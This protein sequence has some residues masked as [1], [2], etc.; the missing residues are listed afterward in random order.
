M[1]THPVSVPVGLLAALSAFV[2]QVVLASSPAG[3]PSAAML[4]SSLVQRRLPALWQ[5]FICPAAVKDAHGVA[6]YAL[7]A[8]LPAWTALPVPPRSL[9]M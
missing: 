5:A 9:A 7:A 2:Q 6:L 8:A 4:H 3:V 1:L